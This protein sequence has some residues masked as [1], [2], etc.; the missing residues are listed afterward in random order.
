MTS[1]K[2]EMVCSHALVFVERFAVVGGENDQRPVV[3][4]CF[5]ESGKESSQLLVEVRD[6][7]IV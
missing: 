6:L 5:L 3:D 7:P 4:A 2:S 1:S